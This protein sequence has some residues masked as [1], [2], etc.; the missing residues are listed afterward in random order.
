MHNL[1]SL[2]HFGAIKGGCGRSRRKCVM[3]GVTA[4]GRQSLWGWGTLITKHILPAWLAPTLSPWILATN[5]FGPLASFC[6]CIC[7]LSFALDDVAKGGGSGGKFESC[8]ADMHNS[9]RGW[10]NVCPASSVLVCVAT[11]Y[12][13]NSSTLWTFFPLVF[14]FFVGQRNFCMQKKETNKNGSAFAF[15]LTYFSHTAQQRLLV[16]LLTAIL[17]L[18]WQTHTVAHQHGR[19]TP[20]RTFARTWQCNQVDVC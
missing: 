7:I 15:C 6:H 16:K 1:L 3:V 8:V 17:G 20:A 9:K 5:S 4:A 10:E 19:H 13:G 2:G 18:A 12:V 14:L 11:F